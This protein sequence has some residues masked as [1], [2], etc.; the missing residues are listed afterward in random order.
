MSFSEDYEIEEWQNLIKIYNTSNDANLHM[1][2]HTHTH[3]TW[4]QTEFYAAVIL[5]GD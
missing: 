5:N 3:K 4:E 1:H 2:A